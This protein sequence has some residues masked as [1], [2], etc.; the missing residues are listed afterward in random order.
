MKLLKTLIATTALVGAA[1][2]ASA[3]ANPA[4]I[5]DLGGKF[6]KSFNEMSYTGA[7]RFTA[8]TGISYREFELQSDAQ[9]EQALRRFAQAGNNPVVV[10]GFS[11]ATAMEAVAP[12]FPDTDF[13]II[14]MVVDLPNVRSVVFAEQ[15]GSYLVGLL[16]AMASK[17]GTVSFVGGMDIPL[18]QNFQCGYAQGAKSV[19]DITVIGA[20][21][22]TDG[23]AWNNPVKGGEITVSQIENGS[24][25][26]FAAAGGT[27]RG[28]LQAATDAGIMA[29][30]VDAN[31]NYMHPGNMLTSM[32]KR[33][34]NA[35]YDAFNDVNNDE[36]TAGI[37]VMGLAEDGVGWSLDEH[38][39]SLITDEM[40]AA[41]AEARAAIIAGDIVVHDY[42]T[43]N[44]CPVEIN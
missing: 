7:E 20:M 34:D 4:L 10:A 32:I 13:V 17:T 42:R 30:G 14:D 27:G 43:D 38:N 29:I 23:S 25:V 36:F 35:V 1:T 19:G 41:V 6:D 44:T 37:Q 39:E 24:D 15:E 5:F 22:G 11:N 2:F 26:V 18:I 31:Q 33:V 21:T 40:R 3:Q 8:D 12:D 9:R 16:A 28:V